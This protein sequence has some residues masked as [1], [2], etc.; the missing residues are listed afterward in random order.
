LRSDIVDDLADDVEEAPIRRTRVSD[1]I[2]E[3]L[4]AQIRGGTYHIGDTL[5]SERQ[6][7]QRFGVGRPA[8]REALFT[9][10]KRGIVEVRSGMKPRVRA[11]DAT[12]VLDDLSSV[13]RH[14]LAQPQGVVHFQQLRAFLEVALAR[15]AARNATPDEI[16]RLR[17]ALA[18]NEAA[19]GDREA[20]IETDV[21]FHF[22]LAERTGNAIIMSIHAAMQRWLYEQRVVALR[23]PDIEPISYAGHAAV[24]SA[25]M[26]GDAD[27]AE[28]AMHEHLM[29]VARN[30]DKGRS[31]PAAD[32]AAH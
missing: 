20:F 31:R 24:A 27:A 2:V 12:M 5:P 4:E 25:I 28:R 16:E 6:L 22:V 18:A 3:R 26:A 13:A 30:Y 21:A 14:F 23:V 8:V 17:R 7:M 29:E 10:S 32:K 11:P 19:I 15:D 9:L 1:Q